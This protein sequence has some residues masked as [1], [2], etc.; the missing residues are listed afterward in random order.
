MSVVLLIPG[1]ISLFLVLRGRIKTAFLSV[2]LP[3]LL[4]LPDEYSYK[5]PHLPLLSAAE[6]ALIP[7]GVVALTRHIRSGSFRLMD[8]LVFSFWVSLSI[9]E[10]SREPV[11]N[12][13]ILC[14][15]GVFVSQL[16]AYAVGRQLIEPDLRFETARR[17]SIF[18]L[19][20]APFGIY[21][22]WTAQRVYGILGQKLHLPDM[23]STVPVRNG[24][25]RLSVSLG[26][27]ELTGIAI[28]VTFALNA[29]LV[30][31]KKARKGVNLGKWLT[32]LEKYHVPGLVFLLCL[33]MTQ[34]RGPMIATVA[35]YL[36]IQIARFKTTKLATGL[37]AIL[38]AIG[39]LQA[40]QYYADYTA[41]RVN[42]RDEE[43][44]SA[45]YRRKM[46]IVYQSIAASGGWLGWAGQMP[47][48]EGQKSIDNQFLLTHL[49][50]GELGYI[51]LILIMAESIRNGI[52][53]VWSIQTLEDR[54]F[55]CCMLA[56]FVIFWISY[57]TVFMGGPLPQ[58]TFL[59]LG[60]GQSF[61]PR[62]KSSGF[63]AKAQSPSESPLQRV[64][65]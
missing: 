47:V 34:S 32:R 16:L 17:W 64:L 13:G 20:L 22:W 21:E 14:A 50:Q 41:G 4:L 40:Q 51:L 44:A 45:Q 30:I 58:I 37:V 55:A 48:V 2:Y 3:S 54:A 6:Y 52:A 60:W 23:W 26:G 61:V 62:K 27:G 31:L 63:A 1:C 8:A 9:T 15:A 35:G 38:L 33:W 56:I 39:A 10:I 36:I 18:V 7:I 28:G 59:M 19:L 65:T 42:Y 29:W 25:G 24:R 49:I 43:R 11:M 53:S 46:N 12:D 5:I 57:Y